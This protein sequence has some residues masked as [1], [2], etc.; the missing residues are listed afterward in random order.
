MSRLELGDAARVRGELRL[1]VRDVLV[2]IPRR[3][4]A[5]RAARRAAPARGCR[6]RP[7]AGSCRTARLP[8]RS[9]GDAGGI[10]PGV[11]PP[12]SAWWA[13]EA[14]KNEGRVPP[15]RREDRAHDRDV[16]QVRA[17]RVGRIQHPGAAAAAVRRPFA[18]IT[19]R[20]LAPIEPRCTG[21]CGAFAMRAP[22]RRRGRRRNRGARGCSRKPQ[23]PA[24]RRPSAPR[25]A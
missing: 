11:M 4:G 15:R 24:A 17:A 25:P 3:P 23:S 16:R 13:R 6:R 9:C 21:M 8:R 1:E 14:T 20:T 5:G 7:A 10:E 18:S 2:G 22:R 12:M 19:A